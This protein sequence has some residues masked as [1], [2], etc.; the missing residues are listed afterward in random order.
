MQRKKSIADQID[1]GLV[2]GAEQQHHVGGQFF[3]AELVA[4]LL[5]LHQVRGQIVGRRFAAHVTQRLEIIDHGQIVGVMLLDLG[6][7]EWREIEQAAGVARAVMEEL[8]MLSRDAEHVA[9][10]RHRQAVGEVGDQVHETAR[11]D[12]IDDPI[13]H[14][15]DAR[16]HILDAPRAERAHHQTAQPAVIGRIELKHPV[17]HT[18]IDRLVEDLRTGAPG[19]AALEVSAKALVAQDRGDVGVAAGDAE[20]ERRQVHRLGGAQ[21]M[22][23]GVRIGNELRRPWIEQRFALQGLELLVHV[24]FR[25]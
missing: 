4:G 15:L 18:A 16:P 9:D 12:L 19:H 3:V 22:I 1:C 24:A 17:T 20:T 13:D 11:G 21:P 6:V 5:G 8:P 7:G 2:T 14:R 23:V 25:R 10:Y